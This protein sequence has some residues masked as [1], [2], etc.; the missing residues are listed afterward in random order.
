MGSPFHKGLVGL[1]SSPLTRKTQ[2]AEP[3]AT[4]LQ[5]R[6]EPLQAS[7]A[8]PGVGRQVQGEER[9]ALG[10]TPE[11]GSHRVGGS[12]PGKRG[13]PQDP[14]ILATDPHDPPWPCMP[15]S[16]EWMAGRDDRSGTQGPS[17]PTDGTRQGTSPAQDSHSLVI[18]MVGRQSQT[19]QGTLVLLAS[20]SP[21]ARS[22]RHLSLLPPSPQ[23]R[24]LCGP[25]GLPESMGQHPEESL[26]TPGNTRP[27][28][29]Q[30]S[31]G[32][33]SLA[34]QPCLPALAAGTCTPGS[35]TRPL[36]P[37]GLGHVGQPP[38]S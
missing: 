17:A 16:R 36:P 24:P 28:P 19:C 27:N 33:P 23:N 37:R 38:H 31:L 34:L 7:T 22:S 26:S 10:E 32:S 3:P 4:R 35:G 12:T 14:Q 8:D 2:E 9:G 5:S 30:L 18:Q 20:R 21:G 25:H 15:N 1:R 13:G 29:R 11:T 6:Q